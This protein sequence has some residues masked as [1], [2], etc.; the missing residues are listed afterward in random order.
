MNT[1]MSHYERHLFI[2]INQRDPDADRPSCGMCGTE[3]LLKHAKQRA[4]AQGIHGAGKV[5]VN[6]SGCLDRCEEGPVCVVYPDAVW[7]TFVDEED[8]DEIVD[9]HLGRGEPVERLRI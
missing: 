2:C 7:Y 6:K 9:S 1:G 3:Q 4:K 8:L 5:R